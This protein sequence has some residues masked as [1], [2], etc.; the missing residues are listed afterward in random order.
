MSSAPGFQAGKLPL[1]VHLAISYV[2]TMS[3][4]DKILYALYRNRLNYTVYLNGVHGIYKYATV[5]YNG[6]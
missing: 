3:Y 2:G 1:E 4:T 6:G 5:R